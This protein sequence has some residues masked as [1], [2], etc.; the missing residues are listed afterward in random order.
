[1]LVKPTM[2]ANIMVTCGDLK[3]WVATLIYKR[4]DS[5]ESATPAAAGQGHSHGDG[6]G[7]AVADDAVE[8]D[9]EDDD[10]QP[11]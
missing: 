2:S 11:T 6:G 10:D 3:N 9:A 8:N 1:M 7:G 5:S 4:A